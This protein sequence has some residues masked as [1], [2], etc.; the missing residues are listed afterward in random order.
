MQIR[1]LYNIYLQNNNVTTDSRKIQDKVIYFALK[2]DK[3]DGNLFAKEALNK[4]ASCAV[5]DNPRYQTDDRMFLVDNSLIALQQL[6]NFHRKQF[7]G[8]VLAIT[9]T[10]GKTT[11]KELVKSVLAQKYNVL[12]TEGNLNNHI[13]VPLTL[14]SIK[15]ENDFAVVEMGANHPNEIKQL[16]EIA[17]PNFGLITNIGK[18]HLDGFGGFEGVIKTKKELYDFLEFNNGT[19]FYNGDNELITG[20]LSKFKTSKINYG[21]N[22]GSICRGRLKSSDL[23]LHA[24]IQCD[25]QTKF[26]IS[27]HLI[28]NYNFENILAAVAVGKKFGISN[29]AIKWALDNYQPVNNRSQYLET[30]KN[31]LFV[32]CYNANPSSTELALLN[33]F[34][35]KG[36]NK[37]AILGDMLEL[38]DESDNEHRKIIELLVQEKC[39][40]ILVGPVY[41]RLAEKYGIQ[42]FETVMDLN[43]YL[44]KNNLINNTILLK[45]SRGIQLEK[46]IENL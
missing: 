4:G 24:E 38:G 39:R 27:T 36:N 37:L 31:K 6:A 9:G 8:P 14:L 12:A 35:A 26:S 13:G 46:V 11:T 16:C 44:I 45:G 5:I 1:S 30:N 20:I 7:K 25:D 32:D 3:F 17:E 10:N 2:G 42:S 19:I 43:V 18:A 28:G 41:N 29:D 15:P 21:V 22:N 33:F 40:A 23:F 34:S